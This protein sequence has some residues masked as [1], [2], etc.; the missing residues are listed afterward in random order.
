MSAGSSTQEQWWQKHI[1]QADGLLQEFPTDNQEDLQVATTL[2]LIFK[3]IASAAK[4]N[5]SAGL[6]SLHAGLNQDKELWEH[7]RLMFDTIGLSVTACNVEEGVPHLIPQQLKGSATVAYAKFIKNFFEA[8]KQYP[9]QGWGKERGLIML[10]SIQL[11]AWI[12]KL[13]TMLGQYEPA[14]V[15]T[16]SANEEKLGDSTPPSSLSD[17]LR[18]SDEFGDGRRD[19][20]LSTSQ[21]REGDEDDDDYQE[22]YEDGLVIDGRLVTAHDTDFHLML[23]VHANLVDEI[24]ACSDPRQSAPLLIKLQI[25]DINTLLYLIDIAKQPADLLD[26]ENSFDFLNQ[27]AI[28]PEIKSHI[29][30]STSRT[31]SFPEW[32]QEVTTSLREQLSVL[33]EKL[34]ETEKALDAVR[35]TGTGKQKTDKQKQ[36]TSLTA[37]GLFSRSKREKNRQKVRAEVEFLK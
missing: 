9:T 11:N 14:G 37:S 7:V 12:Q 36:R 28:D 1:K 18:S 15:E 10:G 33:R 31:A 29:R 16:V 34:T 22:C 19:T 27:L 4:K 35:V 30:N 32:K 17:S 25:H 21:G 3:K 20:P 23:E 8:V 2:L 6:E 26:R 24:Q 5:S 13:A